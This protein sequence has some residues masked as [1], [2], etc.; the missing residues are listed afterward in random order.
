MNGIRGKIPDRVKNT[1]VSVLIN[2][3]AVYNDYLTGNVHGYILKD[4]EGNEMESCWGF[5]GDLEKSGLLDH[6]PTHLRKAFHLT[7]GT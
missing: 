4:S 6:I 5:L 1:V 7:S 3:V 2:E